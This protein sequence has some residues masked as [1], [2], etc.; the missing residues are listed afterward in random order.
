MGEK[1]RNSKVGKYDVS[2]GELVRKGEF[3]PN[4]S[5][6]PGIFLAVHADRLSCGRCGYTRGLNDKS[7]EPS[8]SEEE[9]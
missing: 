4:A 6:G 7:P 8:S 1:W 2:S 3:C 5:C 9:E